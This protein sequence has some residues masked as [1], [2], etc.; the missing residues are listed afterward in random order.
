MIILPGIFPASNF[1]DNLSTKT[2]FQISISNNEIVYFP[3]LKPIY[4]GI[5]RK[6]R[7]DC[8]KEVVNIWKE[9]KNESDLE[10]KVD[11]LSKI[12]AWFV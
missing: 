8:Q 10:L 7:Q 2:N 11:S 12:G 4:K 5:F 6:K 1:S 3:C 9:I